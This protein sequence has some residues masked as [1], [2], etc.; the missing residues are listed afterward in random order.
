M[1]P[2]SPNSSHSRIT[3]SNYLETSENREKLKRFG[4]NLDILQYCTWGDIGI[5][6]S[7]LG[8]PELSTVLKKIFRHRK[9]GFSFHWFNSLDD[10]KIYVLIWS[11]EKPNFEINFHDWEN[12]KDEYIRQEY[13]HLYNEIHQY[14]LQYQQEIEN[15]RHFKRKPNQVA[16]YQKAIYDFD[17]LKTEFPPTIPS[18]TSFEQLSNECDRL[19]TQMKNICNC[20]QKGLEC[21]Q[22]SDEA[23]KYQ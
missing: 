9:K 2:V 23:E 1:N 15:N 4:L 3:L 21:L 5:E 20:L 7:F 6:Y 19:R 17:Q 12:R 16:L 13:L 22:I 10:G 14:H 11:Q 18:N 8:I